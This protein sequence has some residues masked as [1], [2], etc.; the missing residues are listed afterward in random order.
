MAE[1]LAG[2]G[3]VGA[4]EVLGGAGSTTGTE[5]SRSACPSEG[6]PTWTCT[7]QVPAGRTSAVLQPVRV[8]ASRTSFQGPIARLPSAL[9][10]FTVAAT[11]SSMASPSFS[12]VMS[13]V[14]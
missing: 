2:A 10:A 6:N 8:P 1:G 11:A 4:A 14:R 5:T 3:A 9:V 12:Q 13:V 7:F